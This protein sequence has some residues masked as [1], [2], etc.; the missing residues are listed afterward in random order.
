VEISED[1]LTWFLIQG[2][3]MNPPFARITKNYEGG[4]VFSAYQLSADT[5]DGIVNGKYTLWGYA[6]LSPV[7]SSPAGIDPTNWFTIPDDPVLAG[8]DTGTCGGDAFDID[9]AVDPATGASANMSGFRYIRITTGVDRNLG[10]S[11]GELSTEIDAVA[12][13]GMQ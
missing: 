8:I 7:L 13:I 12:D 10:G 2:S 11:L 1:G 4:Q 6:D 3:N 9:W 5:Q